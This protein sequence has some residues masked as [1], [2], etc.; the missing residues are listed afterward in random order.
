MKL[1]KV[2]QLGTEIAEIS[3]LSEKNLLLVVS[4]T[5]EVAAYNVDYNFSGVTFFIFRNILYCLWIKVLPQ[6]SIF[7]KERV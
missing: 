3:C 7:K 6:N 5:G 2:L 1:N 4:K